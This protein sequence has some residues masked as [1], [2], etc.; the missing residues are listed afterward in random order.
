MQFYDYPDAWAVFK[1]SGLCEQAG[2]KNRDDLY[3]FFSKVGDLN[4]NPLALRHYIFDKTW[5]EQKCPYYNVYPSIIPILTK[6]SLDIAGDSIVKTF[7][8]ESFDEF[9]PYWEAGAQRVNSHAS[10]GKITAGGPRKL[11]NSLSF[12]LEDDSSRPDGFYSDDGIIKEMNKRS[13]LPHLLIRLPKESN[14]FKFNSN[15]EEIEVKTVFMSFQPVNQGVGN[16]LGYGLVIGMDIGETVGGMPTHTMKIFPLNCSSVEETIHKLPVHG[17][18][19]EGLQVPESIISKCVKLCLT[20]RLIGDDPDLIQPD[21]L[22]K[23]R[24][25]WMAGDDELK[26]RLE[27]KARR[28]GKDGVMIGRI[29]GSA[30]GSP[31]IRKPHLSL[32]WTGEGRKIPKILMRKGSVVHRDKIEKI[33]TGYDKR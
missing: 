21:V 18:M 16:E 11:R 19:E 26:R 20:L 30:G 13:Y 29:L 33:P 22:S 32:Y 31:H 3:K 8:D 5:Y 2:L 1:K 24:I 25:R 10:S 6:I 14:E 27:E 9:L 7:V 12:Q 15:N 28:R 23:D 4:H 17:S